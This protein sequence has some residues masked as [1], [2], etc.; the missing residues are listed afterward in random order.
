M[1]VG[2]H[3]IAFC[4]FFGTLLSAFDLTNVVILFLAGPMVEIHL[5]E[6]E[7]QS[8]VRTRVLFLEGPDWI[9]VF[10]VVPFRLRLVVGFVF[11]VV[12]T[13]VKIVTRAA[14]GLF[15]VALLGKVL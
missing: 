14:T 11:L 13:G 1:T 9:N 3:Q 10:L 2:T 7:I 5:T 12:T 6:T 8:A 4:D 15:P